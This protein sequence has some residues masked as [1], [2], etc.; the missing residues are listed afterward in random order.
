MTYVSSSNIS[1]ANAKVDQSVMNIWN[2]FYQV[3]EDE[4]HFRISL[5]VPGIKENMLCIQVED[6]KRVLKVTGYRNVT[7]KQRGVT[8]PDSILLMRLRSLLI[9]MIEGINSS[10]FH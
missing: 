9:L 5:G 1:K 4:K 3:C 7:T 10:N 8:A 6:N 2:G